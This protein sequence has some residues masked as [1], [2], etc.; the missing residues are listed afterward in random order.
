[1]FQTTNQLWYIYVYLSFPKGFL[2]FSLH[3]RSLSSS[4]GPQLRGRAVAQRVPVGPAPGASLGVGLG[5]R[6]DPGLE[7][8]QAR[9]E[10]APDHVPG[11]L[12]RAG[13]KEMAT[14]RK[15]WD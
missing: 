15:C 7:V 3:S 8:V 5:A 13:T 10:E 1:M 4:T 9:F 12:H 6:P 11:A 2:L 14:L